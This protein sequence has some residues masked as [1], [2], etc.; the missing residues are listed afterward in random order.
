MIL[1]NFL[2]FPDLS[3]LIKEIGWSE[4]CVIFGSKTFNTVISGK[5]GLFF[6]TK[7]LKLIKDLK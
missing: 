6:E 3:F 5:Q 1:S 2:T 7:G 4:L